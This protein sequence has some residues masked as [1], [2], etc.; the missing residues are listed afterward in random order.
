[1][2]KLADL[3][4]A[5]IEKTHGDGR[6]IMFNTTADSAWGLVSRLASRFAPASRISGSFCSARS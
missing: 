2:L 1:M 4:P 3:S 6:V 5:M